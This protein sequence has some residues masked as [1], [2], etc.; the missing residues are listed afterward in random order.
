MTPRGTTSP[1]THT[2]TVTG[3]G[4]HRE[5]LLNRPE[6]HNAQN[7]T[8]WNEITLA[9]AHLSADPLVSVVTLRGAGASFSSGIDLDEFTRDGGFIRTLSEHP[10]GFPDPMMAMIGEAQEVITALRRAPF[11]VVAQLHGASLGAGFQL[12]LACDVRIAADSARLALLESSKGLIPDLGATWTL[13]RLIGPQAAL[14]LMLTGREIDGAHA[15]DLGIVLRCCR[16]ADLDSTVAD[17]VAAIASVPRVAIA[18]AKAAV[19]APDENTSMTIA[20]HGQ[21]ACI[22]A[23]M[24]R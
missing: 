5:I 19:N 3:T 9:V 24:P 6:R 21:A 13:P 17:Y 8:M 7:L 10:S 16:P 2:I 22:R 11:L 12:A 15:A 4:P 18:S 1:T 14:D 20:G 23:A